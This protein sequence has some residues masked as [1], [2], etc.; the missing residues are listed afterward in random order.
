MN[1]SKFVK[2][3]VLLFLVASCLATSRNESSH[4][5]AT[6]SSDLGT[7]VEDELTQKLPGA[8]IIGAKKCGTR[9]LLKFIGAH[10]NVSTAGSEVHF[11][12]RFYHMGLDW[13]R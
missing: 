2:A 7:V 9:A 5:L 13:Y 1:D 6:L 8:I 3:C 10:P 11:F 4:L 12:D